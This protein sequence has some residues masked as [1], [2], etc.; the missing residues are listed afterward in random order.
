M[1][2]NKLLAASC[3]ACCLEFPIPINCFDPSMMTEIL[4]M[5]LCFGPFEFKS[6]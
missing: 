6:C 4:K 5:G 1:F 2:F 3:C